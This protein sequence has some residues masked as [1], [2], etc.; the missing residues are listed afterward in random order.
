[1]TKDEIEK[2]QN[3]EFFELLKNT[4]EIKNKWEIY[5]LGPIDKKSNKNISEKIYEENFLMS[6][7]LEAFIFRKS[8]NLKEILKIILSEKVPEY[9]FTNVSI[10]QVYAVIVQMIKL[11]YI[12]PYRKEET[13]VPIFQLTELGVKILRERTLQNLALTSFY[14]Y[15]SYKLNKKTVILSIIALIV[16]VLAIII[17]ILIS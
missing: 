14:S 2:K 7:I 16:S 1:M 3:L 15:Q 12:E 10:H 5:N 6:G 8:L 13:L 9:F 4:K 17:S 11:G